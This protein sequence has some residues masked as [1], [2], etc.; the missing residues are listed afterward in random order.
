[1][2]SRRP[3]RSAAQWQALVHRQAKSTLSA[4]EFCDAQELSYAS[5]IQ[6]RS[7]LRQESAASEIDAADFIELT[8][9]GISPPSPVMPAPE[10]VA[11][12]AV[13]VELLLGTGITL[14]ISQSR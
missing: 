8:G 6:W 12:T 14:R 3:Y 13:V 11:D 5:F 7:R 4:R 9:T 10:A 2:T 1:M